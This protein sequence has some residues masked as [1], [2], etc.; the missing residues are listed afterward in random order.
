[1]FLSDKYKREVE[2]I[3]SIPKV[4]LYEKMDHIHKFAKREKTNI[5]VS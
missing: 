1:V 4:G 3:R 5:I 2:T